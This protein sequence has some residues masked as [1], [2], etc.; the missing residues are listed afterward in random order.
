MLVLSRQRDETIMIGDD[1]EVTVVDIRGDKV[2]LGI[3]APQGDQRPSQG[4][5]RR[6]PAGEPRR[7]QVK[8]E[9][10]SGLGGPGPATGGNK[11]AVHQADRQGRKEVTRR[12]LAASRTRATPSPESSRTKRCGTKKRRKPTVMNRGLSPVELPEE[13]NRTGWVQAPRG[14]SLAGR[15]DTS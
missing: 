13:L 10:V 5:L 4:S 9:D 11:G 15:P 12:S 6:H 14:L 2:R 1:I 3:N 7:G 8:P